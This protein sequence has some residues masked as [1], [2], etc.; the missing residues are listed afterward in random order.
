MPDPTWFEYRHHSILLADAVR[1]SAFS[2]AIRHRIQEGTSVADIG[3]GTGLL[4]SYAALQTSEPIYAIEHFSGLADTASELLRPHR[5]VQVRNESSYGRPFEGLP[6][7]VI[8]ETIG[9]L[10]PEENIVELCYEFW[11]RY[12]SV[13]CFIPARLEILWQPVSSEV[14][15]SDFQTLIQR[16]ESAS[17]PGADFSVL[18][19]RLETLYCKDLQCGILEKTALLGAPLSLIE[20]ELGTTPRSGFFRKISLL[21][22]P[23]ANAVHLFFRATLDP[24]T[25]LSSGIG[26]PLTHWRHC[27]VRRPGTSTSLEVSYQ[28]SSRRFGFDWAVS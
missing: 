7:V 24:S 23:S 26:D 19:A 14:V 27:F 11:K 1:N 3:S 2:Q 6:E 13:K 22:H 15:E 25:E 21:D 16:F 8:T 4:S 10:G 28:S 18:R 20:Y 9:S 5:Q 17:H 12:P